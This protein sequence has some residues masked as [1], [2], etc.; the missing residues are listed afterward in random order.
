MT[1]QT[2]PHYPLTTRILLDLHHNEQL[3]RIVQLDIEPTYGYVGRIVYDNGAVRLFRRTNVGVNNHGACEI[4]KDKGYTKYF[5]KNLGIN[6]PR[7]KVFLLPKYHKLIDGNLARYGFSGYNLVD[8]I[9]RYIDSDL[10]YPVFIKP[11]DESQGKGVEMCRTADDVT[12]TLARATAAGFDKLIVEDYVPYADYRVVVLDE[13]VVCAYRRVPLQI[14]GTGSD[15][16]RTL[17]QQL[18]TAHFAQGRGSRI[19]LDDPRLAAHL[20]RANMTLDSIPAA[21]LALTLADISNLTAGG[22][23][24]DVTQTLHPHWQKL[25]T[26]ITAKIGLRLCGVDLACADITDPAAPYSIIET[27]ASP[28]LDH[29]A[30]LGAAA[31]A[32]VVGLYRDIFG[33]PPP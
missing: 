27:N 31:Y 24:I 26:D 18:A 8:D 5:L 4:S 28:G 30:A 14:T 25:C 29:Y 23:A 3:P 33:E 20:K 7:G 16:V 6:T 9:Y 17:L 15:S 22:T 21:G 12:H 32:R 11:N 19:D 13:R 2:P 1:V 10:G